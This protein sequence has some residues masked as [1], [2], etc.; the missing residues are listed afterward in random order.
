MDVKVVMQKD[1]RNAVKCVKAKVKLK[2][3]WRFGY[4]ADG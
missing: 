3:K 4:I 2:T 1:E